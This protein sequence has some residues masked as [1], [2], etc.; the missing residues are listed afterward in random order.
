MASPSSDSMA[1]SEERR[2]Q[3]KG[4]IR[5][6]STQVTPTHFLF[7]LYLRI[8]MNICRSMSIR[9][10]DNAM[11][12]H[13]TLVFEVRIEHDHHILGIHCSWQ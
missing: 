9:G 13:Q 7:T 8:F 2:G 10:E 11:V 4:L 5:G 6:E 1:D 3:A 12:L